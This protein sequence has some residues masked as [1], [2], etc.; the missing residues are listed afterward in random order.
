[1]LQKT[2]TSKK[3]IPFISGNV[4]KASYISQKKKKKNPPKEHFL[5]VRKWKP[6]KNFLHFLKCES[7]SYILGSRNPKKIRY[8]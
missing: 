8:N 6:T 5:Y 7:C 4:K 3:K 1:M 2:K